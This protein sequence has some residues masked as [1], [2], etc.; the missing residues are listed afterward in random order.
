[1]VGITAKI[2]I[3]SLILISVESKKDRYSRIEVATCRS[4]CLDI[5]R[6]DCTSNGGTCHSCWSSCDST[7]NMDMCQDDGCIA[8][9]TWQEHLNAIGAVSDNVRSGRSIQVW[10][11]R[12]PLRLDQCHL[13]WGKVTVSSNSFR[14]STRNQGPVSAPVYIVLGH[15]M[16]GDWFEVAQTS[17]RTLELTP[18]IMTDVDMLR[19]MVVGEEGVRLTHTMTVDKDQCHYQTSIT[20]IVTESVIDGQNLLSVSLEWE[21]REASEFLVRWQEYPL[22]GSAMATLVVNTPAAH[23]T[24]KPETSYILQVENSA[25][26]EL[27]EPI[28]INTRNTRAFA[29][30]P[31][32]IVIITFTI[33][34]LILTI[35]LGVAIVRHYKQKESKEEKQLNNNDIIDSTL[36]S[37]R[38]P[39]NLD[40]NNLI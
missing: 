5:F 20:P 3:S 15:H 17:I 9:C 4:L 25:N 16:S 26:G 36:P 32:L 18:G 37:N 12:S 34:T 29:E 30:V 27:S 40:Y 11:V 22:S 19:L 21:D 38:V 24:L 28:L 2:F 1:M 31:T 35:A 6:D 39:L 8:A 7:C 33:V 13:S 14:S 10:D 23:I